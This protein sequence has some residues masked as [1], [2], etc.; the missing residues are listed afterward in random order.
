MKNFQSVDDILDFAISNEQNAVDLYEKLVRQYSDSTIKESLL[1]FADEEKNHK[2]I[3]ERLK[4]NKSYVLPLDDVK[5]MHIADFVAERKSTEITTYADAL[6]FAMRSEKAA[7][8]LYKTLA[9]KALNEEMAKIFLGLA[10]EEAKHRLKFEL[11]YDEQ[12]LQ[13]GVQKKAGQ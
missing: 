11:E 8:L 7:Y 4:K 1:K 2:M 10:Q 6:G 13:G 5:D 3:L 12:I 9:D